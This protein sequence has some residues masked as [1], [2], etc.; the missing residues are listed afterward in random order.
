MVLKYFPSNGLLGWGTWTQLQN[1]WLS[2]PLMQTLF[3]LHASQ[4]QSSRVKLRKLPQTLGPCALSSSFSVA[5][6]RLL[7]TDLLA[8]QRWVLSSSFV[9]VHYGHD[10]LK[11]PEKIPF[12]QISTKALVLTIQRRIWISVALVLPLTSAKKITII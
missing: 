8:K 3:D 2:A 6:G 11:T 1:F 4:T 10:R 9:D 7:G 5:T 12:L